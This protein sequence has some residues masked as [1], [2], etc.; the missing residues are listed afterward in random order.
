MNDKL[1]NN[2]NEAYA[3][4]ICLPHPVS[5]VHPQMSNYDRAAQFSPFAALSGHEEAIREA[6]RL[7]S[8]KPE[9]TES[10]AEELNQKLMLLENILEAHPF[11]SVTYFK[12]DERKDGGECL[13]EEGQLMR[14]LPFEKILQL[15]T[16]AL[17]PFADILE[18]NG[19]MF[20][21]SLF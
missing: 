1:Q 12:Q 6:Q 13:T 16:G 14:I 2:E 7:I 21:D 19:E 15:E 9:L 20:R 8:Q 18:I 10:M 3:D 11:I 4:I 5:K 17:I